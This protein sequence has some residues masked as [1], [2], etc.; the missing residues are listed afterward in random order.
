[1]EAALIAVEENF[2]PFSV[3]QSHDYSCYYTLRCFPYVRFLFLTYNSQDY[4]FMLMFFRTKLLYAS[5]NR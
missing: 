4:F 3:K 2:N 5:A 1:M